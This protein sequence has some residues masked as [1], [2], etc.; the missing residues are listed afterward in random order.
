[1]VNYSGTAFTY[2]GLGR[3]LS[4]GSI[5]YTYDSNGRIIKQSNGIEFLYDNTGVA[6]IVYNNA[7]YLYRKDAQGNI[8]AILD[9]NGNVV[10]QY[11]Y[12]AW[13]NHSVQD[14]N[15]ADINDAA[16]IGSINPFRYRG[17]YYD[18]EI[19]LYY[20]KSR[21]Y[22]PEVGRFITIDDI[23]YLNLEIINGLN[24][25]AY[26]GNN[27]V[28]RIDENG[29]KWWDWLLGVFS[30]VLTVVGVALT[31]TG[32]GGIFGGVL[33]S[34]GV[35]SLLGGIV[36][37]S[38]GGS[39]GAGWIGGLIGGAISGAVGGFAIM[40]IAWP[41]LGALGNAAGSFVSTLITSGIN[42]NGVDFKVVKS[43]LINAGITF[44]VSWFIG[45]AYRSYMAESFQDILDEGLI[46]LRSAFEYKAAQ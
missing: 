19:G 10:V 4:K 37:Q 12:D 43:A 26:C 45:G 34:A 7:T 31:V 13:G 42:N 20:L 32:I 17:Y 6:G 9:S 40:S 35:S 25:Y 41:V 22:D 3:R 28:M 33:I 5:N 29:N 16:H 27:P 23:S 30:V 39:F 8:C 21:Y 18:T 15:G 24:L 38:Q 2:D 14:A 36:N 46:N 1:M 44:A 11:K